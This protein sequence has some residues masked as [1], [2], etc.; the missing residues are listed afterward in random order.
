MYKPIDKLE[1]AILYDHEFIMCGEWYHQLWFVNIYIQIWL[2]LNI[3]F[4]LMIL[5]IGSMY[6]IY[7][8]IYHPYTPNVSI[9]T[10]HGSYGLSYLC[11]LGVSLYIHCILLLYLCCYGSSKTSVFADAFRLFNLSNNLT[12]FKTC[13]ERLHFPNHDITGGWSLLNSQVFC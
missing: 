2:I 11:C 13:T 10:I 7:G 9:Y 3:W 8:N 6:A 4:V 1:D 5:P 12:C